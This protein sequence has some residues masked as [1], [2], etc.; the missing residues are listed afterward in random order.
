PVLDLADVAMLLRANQL[1]R[2]S[3]KQLSHL[4]IDE[5][6]DLSPVELAALIGETTDERSVTLAGDTS[7]RLFLDNGF[8]DWR[9]V[10]HELGLDHVAVEPLRISYRSTREILH[11][12][13]FAMGP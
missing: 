10:L 8:R 7:Q 12:A 3:R 13:R 9:T 5:A 2:G 11:L 1:V 6:Q 4:F